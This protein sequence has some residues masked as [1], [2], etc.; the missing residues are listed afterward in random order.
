MNS[1]LIANAIKLSTKL[2][3]IGTEQVSLDSVAISCFSYMTKA[4]FAQSYTQAAGNWKPLAE[5][6]LKTKRAGATW[7]RTGKTYKTFV[8]NTELPEGTKVNAPY[9]G[10]VIKKTKNYKY[11]IYPTALGKTT[12]ESQIYRALGLLQ[13]GYGSGSTR[14]GVTKDGKGVNPNPLHNW[15]SKA[16]RKKVDG[17]MTYKRV[18]RAERTIYGDVLDADG[19]P[20]LTKKGNK[21]RMKI[22]TEKIQKPKAFTSG[23]H[24]RPWLIEISEAQQQAM[25]DYVGSKLNITIEE[26]ARAY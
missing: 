25:F 2:S 23:R 18:K 4:G 1:F 11:S 9:G 20:K 6:T 10:L 14:W 16:V 12:K 3:K 13:F 8:R 7:I 17:R 21:Q 19:R 15:E 24:G 5:S 26:S 22:G